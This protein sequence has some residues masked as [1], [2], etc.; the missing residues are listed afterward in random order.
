[1][2]VYRL[3]HHAVNAIVNGTEIVTWTARLA[4]D[5]MTMRSMIVSAEIGMTRESGS[6]AAVLI[7]VRMTNS[8][9]EMNVQQL[10]GVVD[11]KKK[12]TTP[13]EILGI[14][15]YVKSPPLTLKL[16]TLSHTLYRDSG[17]I[18]H[19]S[20]PPLVMDVTATGPQNQN[21]NQPK[22]FEVAAKKARLKNNRSRLLSPHFFAVWLLNFAHILPDIPPFYILFRTYVTKSCS[23][24]QM[25]RSGRRS[26]DRLVYQNSFIN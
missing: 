3:R 6:T 17:E 24:T 8:P 23:F 5:A 25:T 14:Q 18:V 21:Q 22:T 26:L 9:M 7:E 10:L 20:A 12:T 13:V 1:V 16:P 11:K 15:R 4:L 19:V 2:V